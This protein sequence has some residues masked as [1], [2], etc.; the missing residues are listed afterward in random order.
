MKKIVCAVLMMALLLAGCGGQKDAFA[1]GL[2]PK[3]A[4]ASTAPT[5]FSITFS[6][7]SGYIFNEIYISPT[8]SNDWGQELL[9]STSVLKAN[10]SLDVTVPA[11]DYDSY[12]IRVVDED[13]DEYTFTR[14]PL[15]DGSEVAIYFGDQGLA[16]D[17]ADAGGT[18]TATVVGNLNGGGTAAPAETPTDAAPTVTGTGNDTNG[19][20]S[21]TVYN[22]S[23]YDIYAIYMGVS[24]ATAS[25]DLDILPQ[26]LPA[27]ESIEL[28]GLASQGDW[29]NTEWTLN[30]V[31]VDGDESLSFDSFNPWLV[32][33][34][35]ITWDSNNGGY[36][37]EFVYE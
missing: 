4:P 33:Y 28:V 18:L 27:G 21:F 24:N 31:D 9:G 30:V 26:I 25:Q 19:Q 29:M 20:Y 14:V 12:D 5:E 11:Y 10:G 3:E 2:A 17:V 23:S 35:N 1:S 8:A 32:S 15:Q 6:N 37:C 16:A 22:E 13:S 7:A 34:I 36:L